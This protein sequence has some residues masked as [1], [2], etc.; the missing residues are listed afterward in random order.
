MIMFEVIHLGYIWVGY[1]R[2]SRRLGK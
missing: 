1:F 2:H